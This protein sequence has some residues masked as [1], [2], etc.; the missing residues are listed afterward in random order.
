MSF[1]S[2]LKKCLDHAQGGLREAPGRPRGG[3][4]DHFWYVFRSIFGRFL[5]DVFSTF[6]GELFVIRATIELV[7]K[8]KI[9]IASRRCSLVER[10]IALLVSLERSLSNFGLCFCRFGSFCLCSFLKCS[11]FLSEIP[12]L[13]TCKIHCKLQYILQFGKN[14]KHEN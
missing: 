4:G 10:I 11:L 12:V 7:Q 9:A 1:H 13:K 6:I 8:A 2:F 14:K 3:P 5:V